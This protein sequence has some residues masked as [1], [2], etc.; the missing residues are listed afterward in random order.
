M[1]EERAW[2]LLYISILRRVWN[3]LDGLDEDGAGLRLLDEGIGRLEIWPDVS[4]EE[5]CGMEAWSE[6]GHDRGED[7]PDDT[8]LLR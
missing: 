1:A 2:I 7:G 5:T 4:T 8:C 6:G 3:P